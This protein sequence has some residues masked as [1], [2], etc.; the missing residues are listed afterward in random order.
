VEKERDELG[1]VT[2]VSLNHTWSAL[3]YRLLSEKDK[4]KAARPKPER[5]IFQY[6]NP[7]SKEVKLPDYL[8]QAFQKNKKAF[9]VYNKLPFT[10][11]KEYLEWII[12]A[13]KEETRAKRIATMMSR[14]GT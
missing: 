9:A 5:E 7:A 8:Q 14:L 2:L 11:K 3:G 4:V 10:H 1:F 6:V 12:T 13:K